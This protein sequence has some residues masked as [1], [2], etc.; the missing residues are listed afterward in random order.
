M[1]MHRADTENLVVSE[2]VPRT[3]VLHT[4]SMLLPEVDKLLL[5]YSR[6]NVLESR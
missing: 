5:L 6:L 4:H 3:H 1:C 2:H